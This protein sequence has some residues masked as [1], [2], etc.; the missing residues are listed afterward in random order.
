M[1]LANPVCFALNDARAVGAS[2]IALKFLQTNLIDMHARTLTRL[3]LTY[4]PLFYHLMKALE[5]CCFSYNDRALSYNPLTTSK[6]THNLL[7][8]ECM[9][10]RL[11]S[12]TVYGKSIF[13]GH[14]C[15]Q[16]PALHCNPCF[17]EFLLLLSFSVHNFRF[18]AFRVSLL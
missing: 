18:S 13:D 2:V 4:N 17:Q 7:S 8:V 6:P 3:A 10:C 15:G 14:N 9:T 5:F 12:R 1:R 16:L 11:C